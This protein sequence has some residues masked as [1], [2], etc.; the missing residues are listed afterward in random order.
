MHPPIPPPSRSS[1][2][3]TDVGMRFLLKL[4]PVVVPIV[5]A[6]MGIGYDARSNAEAV[7]RIE[8][9]LKTKVEVSELARVS[10]DL[11]AATA[12]A[13]E[14]GQRMRTTLEAMS[15]DLERVCVRVRCDR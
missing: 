5:V 13:R 15:R 8:G 6:L 11:K 4:W 7:A 14:E 1:V 3:E 9:Q 2:S 10:E 12:S